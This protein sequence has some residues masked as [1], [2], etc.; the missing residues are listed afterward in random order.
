MRLEEIASNHQDL[1][2]EKFL[3][4]NPHGT[5]DIHR[6]IAAEHG[7]D[8]ESIFLIRINDK[9]EAWRKKDVVRILKE[10]FG[11]QEIVVLWENENPA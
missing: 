7:L 6:E 5:D 2:A 3:A 11:D 1:F 10:R 9:S 8:A 4:S